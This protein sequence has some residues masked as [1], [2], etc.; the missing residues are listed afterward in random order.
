MKFI[1]IQSFIN[2]Q[3]SKTDTSKFLAIEY[4]AT[5]EKIGEA[6]VAGDGELKEAILHAKTAQKHWAALLPAD[7]ARI[8][9]RAS[10]LIREKND[11]LAALEVWDTGKPIQEALSVDIVSGADAVEYFAHAAALLKGDYYP[12]GKNYAYSV[13]EPLGV[14]GGIGAWNYPFQIACWKSA[15]ALAGGN[16][17][18][19]KPSELTMMT[20]L[21]LAEI[22]Q[23]AGL[24]DGLFQVLL[25][26]AELGKA[27]VAHPDI[28]KI[29]LTGEVGTG[30]KIMASAAAT[31]KH[32]TLELGG[33]SPLVIFDDADISNAVQAAMMANFYT[34]GEICSNGTRV[35][36][37]SSIEKEFLEELKRCT[38]KLIVGDPMDPATQIGALIDRNHFK[39]VTGYIEL[40]TKGGAKRYIGSD[41]V[42]LNP[43]SVASEDS[44]RSHEELSA[45]NFVSPTVFTECNDEMQIVCEEIFGPVMSVLNFDSEEEAIRRANA[46]PFGLAAG[47]FTKDLNRAHRVSA[48][49]QAGIV[50][51]NNYNLTPIEI[52]FGG[53]K[54]SGIGREN[55]MEAL[56]HYTQI[57]T[58]FV[59]N[60]DVD[61]PYRLE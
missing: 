53:Y 10:E 29:S 36:V 3:Y 15:P 41:T 22:Y 61:S 17:M 43:S 42:N 14:V 12:L 9:H 5:N 37:H 25:G 32:V 30:K 55:S 47:L 34:Q 57:K 60:G 33:K 49:L 21:K 7:R 20:A 31:L 8:L 19:F 45:G 50:W 23:A 54:Q 11:E 27:M 6:A 38:E 16:A 1:T 4:P 58:V 28:H 59:E 2:G 39:K 26:D 56:R 13:P 44:G 46:T 48:S 51:I 40:G 18:I 35:F 52:P 24:P